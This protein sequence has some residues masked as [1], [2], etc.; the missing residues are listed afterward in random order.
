MPLCDVCNKKRDEVF[1]ITR[2]FGYQHK[3]EEVIIDI[4]NKC[5]ARNGLTLK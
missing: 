5:L 4:C 1:S 2:Y 3:N